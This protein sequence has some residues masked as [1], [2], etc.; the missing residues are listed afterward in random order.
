MTSTSARET[1]YDD[2]RRTY[3]ACVV[4]KVVKAV[5]AEDGRDRRGD[6]PHAVEV[7]DLQPDDVQ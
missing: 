1:E 4:D 3:D 2:G 6:R 5:L 7:G